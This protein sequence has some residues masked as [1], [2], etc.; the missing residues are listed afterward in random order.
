MNSQ[1]N[2]YNLNAIQVNKTAEASA[3]RYFNNYFDANFTITSD[4]DAAVI[5]YFETVTS[6][7]ES[8]KIIASAVI[9]T[10]YTQGIDTMTILDQFTRLPA[11][12]LNQ[13]LTMFLNMQRVGTSFLGVSSQPT[14]NKYV[15]RAVIP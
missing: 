13:Y 2:N 15:A 7:K 10:A 9:Y 1:I 5:S 12:E 4:I 11:G 3:S 8:A 14:A 6:N